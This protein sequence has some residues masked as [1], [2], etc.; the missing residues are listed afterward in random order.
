MLYMMSELKM[1]MKHI[2]SFPFLIDDKM[3]HFA[4]LKSSVTILVI[5][6]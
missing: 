2:A 6:V 5:S 1:E 3:N 4:F